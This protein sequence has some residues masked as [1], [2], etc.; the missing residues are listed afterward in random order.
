MVTDE[1][2]ARYELSIDWPDFPDGVTPKKQRC[3][4]QELRQLLRML[5]AQFPNHALYSAPL[6][7]EIREV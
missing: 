7:I 5:P 2:P 3:D 4:T 1:P 6:M